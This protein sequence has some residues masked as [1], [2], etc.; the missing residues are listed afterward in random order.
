MQIFQKRAERFLEAYAVDEGTRGMDD[1]L[2]IVESDCQSA[3]PVGN[4]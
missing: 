1:R 4:C 3:A 2:K